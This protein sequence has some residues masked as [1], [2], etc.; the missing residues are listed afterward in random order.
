MG[1]NQSENYMTS[2]YSYDSYRVIAFRVGVPKVPNS[3]W[4]SPK[5]GVP[6]RSPHCEDLYIGVYLVP[7]PVYGKIPRVKTNTQVQVDLQESSRW[8]R[9][10]KSLLGCFLSLLD[11]SSWGTGLFG[12]P[13]GMHTTNCYNCLSCNGQT[14]VW[15]AL[16]RLGL[17]DALPEPPGPLCDNLRKRSHP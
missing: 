13:L 15:H 5:L 10:S 1:I 14:F 4:A 8:D 3:I 16:C 7:P 17:H 6:L 2:P 12:G 11:V 9:F